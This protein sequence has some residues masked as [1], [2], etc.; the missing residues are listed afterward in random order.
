[1]K[2]PTVRTVRGDMCRHGMKL[3]GERVYKP[4]GWCSN[5]PNILAQMHKLCDKSHSHASLE[6]GKAKF[7]AI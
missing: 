6:G 5:S 4:T 1:M 2:E 7:A 3:E